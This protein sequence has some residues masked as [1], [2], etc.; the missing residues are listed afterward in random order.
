MRFEDLRLREPLRRAG[1]ATGRHCPSP[2][3]TNVVPYVPG[4]NVGVSLLLSSASSRDPG[5]RTA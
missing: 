2:I 1:R 3:P 5:K 4:G